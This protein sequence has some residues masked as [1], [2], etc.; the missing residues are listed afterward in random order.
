MLPSASARIAVTSATVAADTPAPP[1]SRG[2][3]IAHSPA[4]DIRSTASRGRTRS[5]SRRAASAASSAARRR[6][7]AMA[8][9]SQ[10]IRFAVLVS[11]NGTRPPGNR[12]F[13]SGPER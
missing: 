2:T 11:L 1:W 9:A 7:T 5:R 8:S 13:R 4:R 12:G 3:V 10:L 6:A